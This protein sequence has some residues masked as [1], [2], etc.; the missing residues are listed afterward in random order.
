MKD[1]LSANELTYAEMFRVKSTQLAELSHE[2][3]TLKAG[4]ELA[5]NSKI[6]KLRLFLDQ[7]GFLQVGDR[8]N[9]SNREF[10]IRNPIILLGKQKYMRLLVEKE[11]LT[12]LHAGPTLVAVSL[13]Q[14]FHI[15][16]S[17]R[18]F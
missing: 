4:K 1:H 11:H 17:W 13:A 6:L 10:T 7:H 8:L 3:F 9:L 5:A 18:I 2:I 16:G 15:T 14:R 12:P